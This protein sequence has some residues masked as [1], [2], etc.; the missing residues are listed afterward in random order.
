MGIKNDELRRLLRA[1]N[2]AFV[3]RIEWK[4]GADQ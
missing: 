1:A 2:A 4:A 3:E